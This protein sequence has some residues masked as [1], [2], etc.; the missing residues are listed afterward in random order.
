[1]INLLNDLIGLRIIKVI[2]IYDYYQLILNQGVINIYA[3]IDCSVI[4]LLVN[5]LITNIEVK[6]KMQIQFE[7]NNETLFHI[8]WIDKNEDSPEIMSIHFEN[9][10]VIIVS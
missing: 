5:S 9:G 1:M 3:K 8:S 2:M 10:D 6:E 7:L 4:D